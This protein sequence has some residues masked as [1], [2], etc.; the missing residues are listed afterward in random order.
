MALGRAQALL[1]ER[2]VRVHKSYVVNAASVASVAPRNGGGRMLRLR[3]GSAIPT[4]RSYG[5]A[6]ASLQAS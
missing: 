6:V 3:D 4:G 5:A 1:S 2:F